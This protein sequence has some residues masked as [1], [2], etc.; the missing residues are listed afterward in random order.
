MNKYNQTIYTIIFAAM[1]W[2]PVA[3]VSAAGKIDCSNAAA[4]IK[5]LQNEKASNAERIAKGVSSVMP[6][7]LALHTLTGTEKESVEVAT[8]DYNRMIDESIA[9]IKATCGL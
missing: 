1:F 2:F 8:G 3:N 4:D 9:K 6:I 5:T 7:G